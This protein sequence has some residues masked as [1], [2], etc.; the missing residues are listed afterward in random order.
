MARRNRTRLLLAG[1]IVLGALAALLAAPV[2]DRLSRTI[3]AQAAERPTLKAFGSDWELRRFMRRLARRYPPMPAPAMATPSAPAESVVVTAAGAPQPGITNVQEAGVDEGDIV[4]LHGDTLVVLRRGRLFTIALDGLHP[5]DSINAYPPGV[6]ARGDWYDEMLIAGDRIVVIGYSYGRG[7]TQIDRFR[8]DDK[9]RLAFQDAYQLRSNDYY[10]ARNYASRLIGSRLIVYS[11]RYLPYGDADP[12]EALP[13]LRRWNPKEEGGGR[14]ERIGTAREVYLPPNLPYDQIEAVHTVVSC[15][16]AAAVLGC[17]ATSVFG[18]ESRTFYVSTH[19]VYVWL[20]PYWRDGER[21]RRAPSLVYRLPLDGG[22]PTATGVRGAPVDQFSFRED[23]GVLNVLVRSEGE[24]DAMWAP[25]R[26]SG[27][28][29]LL[30]LPLSAFG[31]GMQEPGAGRYRL[32]PLKSDG[33]DFHN[34]FVGDYVLYGVGNGWGRP[35]NAASTIYAAPVD[36]GA[37]AQLPLPHGVDRIEI[38]GRDAVVVGSDA[39][40]LYFSAVDLA[41]GAAPALG[42][43]YV[44]NGAAQAETRSHGFFFHPEDG[45]GNGVLGLPI[46][47]PARPAYRQLTEDSAAVTFLRRSAGTLRAAGRIGS[48]R[49]A[50][51]GRPMRRVLRRLVRQCAADLHRTAGLCPDGL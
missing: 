40:N 46:T 17:K 50:A 16:L 37:V 47:R 15:D 19:A 34:R 48:R 26:T 39:D 51:G 41:P 38:I 4:K 49:D 24:G 28:V 10:S 42:D 30:R 1:C 32:L 23:A 5:V 20:S 3:A 9:G 12:F 21:G 31:D 45:A 11:P 2:A 35:Q 22:A 25:E 18:P 14:F 29:G 43:R 6:D 7:G 13:A 36:G 27:A 33:Y 8:I 44:Q